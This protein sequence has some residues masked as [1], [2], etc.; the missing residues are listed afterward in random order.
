M[1]L[2][3]NAIFRVLKKDVRKIKNK[4]LKEMLD[5]FVH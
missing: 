1:F 4:N 3:H 2:S 5:E